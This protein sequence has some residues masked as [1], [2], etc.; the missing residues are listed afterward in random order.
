M[1]Q[2]PDPNAVP[3]EGE[4]GRVAPPPPPQ[5]YGET[6]PPSA[7]APVPYGNGRSEDVEPAPKPEPTTMDRLAAIATPLGF[8]LFMFC[9][10]VLDGWAWAWIFFMLPGIVLAW[11]KAGRDD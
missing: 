11:N 8:A 6:T 3:Y 7:P 4:E 10:F 9:G 1:S 5:R 2:A